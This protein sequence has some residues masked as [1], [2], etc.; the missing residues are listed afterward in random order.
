MRDE[1]SLPRVLASFFSY[2]FFVF[3]VEVLHGGFFMSLSLITFLFFP[4]QV[5][6]AVYFF[7]VGERHASAS[8]RC[9][10]AFKRACR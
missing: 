6:I 10:R 3:C 7:S 8:S 4:P 1:I 9:V 5:R 2:Y